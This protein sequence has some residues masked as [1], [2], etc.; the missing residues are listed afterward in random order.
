MAKLYDVIG[1]QNYT[2]LL[3]DPQ[4][5]DLI[6]I[7][8]EPAQGQLKAGMLMYR[9]TSGLYKKATTSQISTSYFLVVLKEDIDTGSSVTPGA[10]AEDAAAYRAG[11]FV[12]GV[13]TYDNSGTA[14]KVTAAHKVVLK[15]QGIMLDEKEATGTFDNSTVTITY[16]GNNSVSTEL[17]VEKGAVKGSTYTI[18]NN[19]DASLSFTAPATKSFSKWNTKADGS[20]TDYAAAASYTANADLVLYA[21]WAS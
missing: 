2:N 3:S 11:R 15:L 17:P 8:V 1:T 19:S 9:A 4:G 6:A 7:P 14:T 13:V 16:N 20:G 21:V 10:A 12:D 5:A 18:L